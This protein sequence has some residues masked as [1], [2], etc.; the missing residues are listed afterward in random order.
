LRKKEA[1]R[2]LLVPQVS[3]YNVLTGIIG[4]RESETRVAE[5]DGQTERTMGLAL[6]FSSCSGVLQCSDKLNAATEIHRRTE[7]AD[8]NGEPL[9]TNRRDRRKRR[10]FSRPRRDGNGFHPGVGTQSDRERGWDGNL[11]SVF[12]SP[13][14]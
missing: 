14:R 4:E 7:S 12:L 3:R 1:I 10:T 2:L 5:D 9:R 6:L 11:A 8:K 13:S